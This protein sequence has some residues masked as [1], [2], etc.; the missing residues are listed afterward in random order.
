MTLYISKL[1]FLNYLIKNIAFESILAKIFI[2]KSIKSFS[3][4][5][6]HYFCNK[7]NLKPK[8]LSTSL[9]T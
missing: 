9:A 7:I 4:Y 1:L 5:I 8:I 6:F 2:K 3:R